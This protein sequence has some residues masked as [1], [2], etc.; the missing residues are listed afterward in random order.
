MTPSLP[1]GPKEQS[2]EWDKMSCLTSMSSSGKEGSSK[3]MRMLEKKEKLYS[4]EYIELFESLAQLFL[5]PLLHE[6]LFCKLKC[7][8]T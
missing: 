2:A 6:F 3:Y 5:N 7:F 4:S 1:G 8:L